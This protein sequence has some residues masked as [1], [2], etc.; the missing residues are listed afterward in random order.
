MSI[1][2]S[3][4]LNYKLKDKV[5]PDIKEIIEEN[6]IFYSISKVILKYRKSKGLTQ[7]EFA[8]KVGVKQAM[9][10][11]IE[12]GSYNPSFKAIYRISR[13]ATNSTKMFKEILKEI[14]ENIE[15]TEEITDEKI[16]IKVE[17]EHKVKDFYKID[18]KEKIIYINDYKENKKDEGENINEQYQ[19]KYTIIG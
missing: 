16:I 15:K 12:S 18:N 8:K 10:S 13:K 7:Q 1:N 6:E 17:N 3:K 11:K 4:L 14:I 19:S 5:T 9:I 2:Y